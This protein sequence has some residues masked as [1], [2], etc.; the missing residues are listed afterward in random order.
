MKLTER[1]RWDVIRA[2]V[3][4]KNDEYSAFLLRFFDQKQ[5]SQIV[6]I[7]RNTFWQKC[8]DN[9][10]NPLVHYEKKDV[11]P[12]VS[13]LD[14]L[15]S[16]D[17]LLFLD[18]RCKLLQQLYR[19]YKMNRTLDKDI[20]KNIAQNTSISQLIGYN[21][22][23]LMKTGKPVRAKDEVKV[24]DLG[25]SNDDLMYEALTETM[26]ILAATY[27]REK[28]CSIEEGK[29]LASGLIT[30]N[31]TPDGHIVGF[32]FEGEII[33]I[34]PLNIPKIKMID[35]RVEREIP[36]NERLELYGFDKSG[37]PVYIKNGE[38]V[39][40]VGKPVDIERVVYDE[41]RQKLEEI[42]SP[43]KVKHVG[44]DV[45]GRPVYDYDGGYY[46]SIGQVVEE[47]SILSNYE[48]DLEL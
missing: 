18:Y 43:L 24:K 23:Y 35:T 14:D 3:K 27:S 4:Q 17:L 22:G 33:D 45:E 36:E 26:G 32:Q 20:I 39:D 37:L 31:A 44:F 2:M 47:T 13:W 21:S 29:T 48:E 30:H 28:K 34:K 25:L 41:H 38:L 46:N 42:N 19:H 11:K 16:E 6:G 15:S 40:L 12:S 1:Q 7:T 5:M 10:R 8:R 9:K